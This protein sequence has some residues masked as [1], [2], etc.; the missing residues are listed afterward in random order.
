MFG[1]E[2]EGMPGKYGRAKGKEIPSVCEHVSEVTP[3]EDQ[4]SS[5]RYECRRQKEVPENERNV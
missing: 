1:F 5:H 2:A 4:L 3:H